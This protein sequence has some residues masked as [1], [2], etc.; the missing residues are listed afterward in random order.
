MVT[1]ARTVD[2]Q[3]RGNTLFDAFVFPGA[4]VVDALGDVDTD[5]GE[6]R[7]HNSGKAPPCT[8]DKLVLPD[9]TP[10]CGVAPK[11]VQDAEV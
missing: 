2:G 4:L 10:I 1:E 3:C 5:P 8:T 7:L 9:D 11:D 6:P